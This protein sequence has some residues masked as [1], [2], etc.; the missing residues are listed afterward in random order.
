MWVI[1]NHV[2]QDD[3]LD[4]REQKIIAKF[5]GEQN[6]ERLKNFLSEIPVTEVRDEVYQRMKG[7]REDLER[8]IPT[9]FEMTFREI[10]ERVSSALG[11]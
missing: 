8:M 4:R 1:A 5:V 2:I 7:A 6:L 11:Q 10:E 3:V 9:N